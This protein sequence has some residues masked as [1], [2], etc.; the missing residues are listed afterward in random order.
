MICVHVCGVM[1]RR[2]VS[3]AEPWSSVYMTPWYVCMYIYVCK[4][5]TWSIEY[6]IK[7]ISDIEVVWT[8]LRHW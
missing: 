5:Y 2:K 4:V 6:Y 3:G 8:Q 1:R 7:K